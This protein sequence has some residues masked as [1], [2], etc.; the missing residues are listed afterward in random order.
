VKHVNR[1]AGIT[2]KLDDIC[3]NVYKR[4]LLLSIFQLIIAKEK[5]TYPL[6]DEQQG[7]DAHARSKSLKP[8]VMEISVLMADYQY[9]N[10]G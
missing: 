9:N 6:T 10:E 4:R 2:D 5:N 1:H 3:G 8:D 7:K